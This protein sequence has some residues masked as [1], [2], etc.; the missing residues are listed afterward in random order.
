MG[1]QSRR[2][3]L[4]ASPPVPSVLPSSPAGRDGARPR[5]RGCSIL[6]GPDPV[7]R[8]RDG[9]RLGKPR[10]PAPGTVTV[11][12]P[13][14]PPLPR[15]VTRRR[16]GTD[17]VPVRLARAA[18]RKSGRC[19]G[20]FFKVGPSPFRVSSS[21]SRRRHPPSQSQ[22]P[23]ADPT[24]NPAALLGCCR[25]H[26][27]GGRRG[28]LPGASGSGPSTIGRAPSRLALP[29]VKESG[30]ALIF[31]IRFSSCKRRCLCRGKN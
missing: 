25:R 26:W 10:N 14:R 23:P 7:C 17:G 15:L 12:L 13:C 24:A 5:R 30:F 1:R 2:K 11:R 27:H 6:P 29:T 20:P 9:T 28:R 8:P 22:G 16:P 3:G 4:R 21:K 19:R 18:E 31:G